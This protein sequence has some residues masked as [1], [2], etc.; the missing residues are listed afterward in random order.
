MKSNRKR[1]VGNAVVFVTLSA[2]ALGVTAAENS[3][4]VPYPEG[5][6]H[7]TFLHSSMMPLATFNMVSKKPCEK[8]CISG[9][10][11]FYANDKAM[12]G[13]RT[14]SYPDGAIITDEVME[15]LSASNGGATEGQRVVVAVMVK[16]SQR[17]SSTGSWG[18]GLFDDGSRADKADAKTRQACYQCHSARK[19]QAYV[20]TEYRER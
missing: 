6:R 1:M 20:Y 18:W 13:L 5:Y 11:H 10:H 19:D 3:P 17:Y 14:G 7:W 12:E 4:G 8:P 2:I 15:W 9:L 16:D